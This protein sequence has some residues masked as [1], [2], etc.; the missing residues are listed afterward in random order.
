[1]RLDLKR[2]RGKIAAVAAATLAL[3]LS[4][5]LAIPALTSASAK[6]PGQAR[7]ARSQTQVLSA[8]SQTRPSSAVTLPRLPCSA[9]A[10]QIR[11]Q[12]PAQ[13]SVPDFARIPGAPTEIWSATIVPASG[14]NPAYCDVKG[15]ISP[16]IQFELKLPTTTW[17]GRYLQMGCGGSCG[18][19]PVSTFPACNLQ[20]QGNFAVA[21]TND[22]HIGSSAGDSLWALESQPL[23]LDFS[24]RAVHKLAVVAKV[25]IASY[26]GSPPRKSYFEGCSDG[27]REALA[28]AQRYPADFNGIVA[29]DPGELWSA[30][31]GEELPWNIIANTGPDGRPILTV[32]KLSVLHA[33]VI[34]KCSGQSGVADGIIQN[35]ESCHF[36]PATLLCPPGVDHPTCL[37]GAQVGVVRKLYRGPVDPQGQRLFP[38]GLPYGSELGWAG[39]IIT[40]PGVTSELDDLGSPQLRYMMLKVG[41]EGPASPAD[42]Q[43]TLRNFRRLVTTY[44]ATSYDLAP[45]R[46]MG[47]KLIIY[48]GFA[49]PLIPPSSTLAYYQEVED[50]M[51]GLHAV[52]KFARLFM[53]PTL[54]HCVGGYGPDQFSMTNAI[55]DWVEKGNAPA[56]VI[57]TQTNSQGGVVR[58]WPVFPYPELTKYKGS[59]SVDS[60]TSYVGK[61]PSPLPNDHFKWVGNYLFHGGR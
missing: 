21:S 5:G 22:G 20:P 18:S 33:A 25:L 40:P 53:I 58:T 45:F 50:H 61:L 16:Q 51:G 8:R 9:L 41:T 30:L 44:D 26:Y 2:A 43:F 48:H 32:A 4:A 6:P 3:I 36:N 27:G 52:Q 39:L 47:G 29:G 37:T 14:K 56:K 17:Q 42:W 34:A 7:S 24:Y 12:H 19:I 60:S 31:V 13:P 59:G 46:D 38:Q 28:E 1:M 35:P 49:D 10:D 55:V 57:T 23:R 11:V 15:L 54:Y